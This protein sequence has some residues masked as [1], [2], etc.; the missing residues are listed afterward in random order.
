MYSPTSVDA[1]LLFDLRNKI[2]TT[3]AIAIATIAPLTTPTVSPILNPLLALDN[4]FSESS[5]RSFTFGTFVDFDAFV[6][7]ALRL[8]VH[9]SDFDDLAIRMCKFLPFDLPDLEPLVGAFEIEGDTERL[10]IDEG[11]VERLGDVDGT[12]DGPTDKEG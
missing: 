2:E 8:L 12:A 4:T 1:H 7:F 6:D 3:N 9:P 11:A 10:G 5:E